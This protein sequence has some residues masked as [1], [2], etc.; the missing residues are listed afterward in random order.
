MTYARGS[1]TTVTPSTYEPTAYEQRHGLPLAPYDRAPGRHGAPS[2]GTSEQPITLP[3]RTQHPLDPA[4]AT[5]D[6][7]TGDPLWYDGGPTEY[8]VEVF[9]AGDCWALA[10]YVAHMTGGRLVTLG[11]PEWR[12]VAVRLDRHDRNLYLD[13]YGLHTRTDLTTRWGLPVRPLDMRHIETFQDYEDVLDAG[14]CY[15]ITHGEASDFAQLL[16]ARHLAEVHHL[17]GRVA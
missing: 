16:T 8:A 4:T 7:Y 9:T 1:V 5:L 13:A 12:H 3:V 2:R 10:W 15:P 11:W 6:A 14:F 17:E